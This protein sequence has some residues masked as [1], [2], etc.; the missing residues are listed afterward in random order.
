VSGN[1]IVDCRASRLR[2]GAI[3][4]DF[5]DSTSDFAARIS[6]RAW[7]SWLLAAA[8]MTPLWFVTGIRFRGR[9]VTTTQT[10]FISTRTH[11]NYLSIN[12]TS[13]E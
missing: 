4:L 9:A 5:R 2:A 10:A 7:K 3:E 1:L 11:G 8:S 12:R 13:T 6:T